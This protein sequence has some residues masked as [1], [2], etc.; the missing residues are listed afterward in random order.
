MTT[1]NNK[2]NF[3]RFIDTSIA[4]KERQQNCFQ[5]KKSIEK[6]VT[7]LQRCQFDA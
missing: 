4:I 6:L 5:K 3:I 1:K 2:K 7:Q